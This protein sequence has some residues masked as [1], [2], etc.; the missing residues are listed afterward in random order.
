MTTYENKST[1]SP[2]AKWDSGRQDA[3]TLSCIT[4]KPRARNGLQVIGPFIMLEA[5]PG[6]FRLAELCGH[7][8][9]P[10]WGK[11]GCLLAMKPFTL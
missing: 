9:C 1:T 6:I 11:A 2:Y 10:F 4:F 7:P 5:A 3:G 8:H